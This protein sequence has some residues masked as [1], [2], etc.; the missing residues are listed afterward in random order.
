MATPNGLNPDFGGSVSATGFD[1]SH[2]GG[3]SITAVAITGSACTTSVNVF[4]SANKFTGVITGVFLSAINTTAANITIATTAGTVATIAKGTSAGVLV[5]SAALANTA[6]ALD[7]TVTVV[8]S[9]ASGTA[10]VFIT[11]TVTK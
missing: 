5:G 10:Y 9:S 4:G 6:I 7:G 11:Y 2:A 1:A 3:V 8:S